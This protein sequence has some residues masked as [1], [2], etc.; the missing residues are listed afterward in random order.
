MANCKQCGR[1]LADA[2]AQYQSLGFCDVRCQTAFKKKRGALYRPGGKG[3][4][5]SPRR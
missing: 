4:R 5:R 2:E 3:R 1:S